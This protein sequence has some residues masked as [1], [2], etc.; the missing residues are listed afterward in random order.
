M[1]VRDAI[2]YLVICK[3]LPRA[4]GEFVTSRGSAYGCYG[5]NN[6]L[7]GDLITET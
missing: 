7:L 2:G 3:E 6:G 4:S 5:N 1:F